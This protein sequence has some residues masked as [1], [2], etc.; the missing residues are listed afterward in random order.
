MN[1]E[2][3]HPNFDEI[4]EKT[5]KAIKL[6]DSNSRIFRRS[7]YLWNIDGCT[8]SESFV[9]GAVEKLKR[10]GIVIPSPL[11]EFDK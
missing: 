3:K 2:I 11:R 1:N 7:K 9:I 4:C 6:C 10:D 8:I 5:A